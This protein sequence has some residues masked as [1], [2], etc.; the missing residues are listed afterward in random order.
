MRRSRKPTFLSWS[1]LALWAIGLLAAV[2]LVYLYGPRLLPAATLEP[3]DSLA[4]LSQPTLAPSPSPTQPASPT[5]PPEATATPAVPTATKRSVFE[6][7]YTP[8]FT[9]TLPPAA[10]ATNTEV[11]FMEAP[12]TIG[13][14]IEGRPIEIWRFGTGPVRRMIVAGIHGGNEWNTFKLATELIDY[15]QGNPEVIPP[16]VTLYIIPVLNPDGLARTLGLDGRGNHRDVDLN[17]NFPGTWAQE[18]DRQGCW[19]YRPLTAGSGP[20][21]E[22]ETQ[23]FIDV[24]LRLR[25]TAIISYHSAALGIFPADTPLG[26]P[27]AASTSLAQ[28]LAEVSPYPYPPVDTGCMYTG[29]LP[30]WAAS[31]GIAAVDLE[32]RNG[33]DTDFEINLG[34]LDAFL[35]WRR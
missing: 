18:W 2:P 27:H 34:V 28:A 24:V 31:R 1:L 10:F 22:P 8:E 19:N 12:E 4:E 3:A 23:A 7:S 15:I 30:D 13:L 14:S 33:R 5:P 26:G 29:T 6:A 17:R 35:N 20:G 16:T 32:L 9:E 21:S 11:P 25:P